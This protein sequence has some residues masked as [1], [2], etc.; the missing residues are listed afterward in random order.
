M[1]VYYFHSIILATNQGDHK[2]SLCMLVSHLSLAVHEGKVV[3]ENNLVVQVHDYLLQT[4][5][6]V[7]YP[8]EP[9]T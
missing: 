4:L 6:R 9:G 1:R 8:N 5:I 2:V 3:Q 7:N